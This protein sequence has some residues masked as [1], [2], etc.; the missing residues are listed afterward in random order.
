MSIKKP[1]RH[2]EATFERLCAAYGATCNK[3]TQDE[4]GWDYFVEF[5]RN[6]IPDLPLDMAPPPDKCL[7]QVKSSKD[8]LK[9]VRIKLS[10]AFEFAFT[11]LP[12]FIVLFVYNDHNTDFESVHVIHFWETEIARTLKRLRELDAKQKTD[13]HHYT[14]TFH[15]K[16]MAH[17]TDSE[18]MKFIESSI[19]R[20]SPTY[21]D[22]KRSIS[23]EVGFDDARFVA[24]IQFNAGVTIDEIVDMQ[25][26]LR[27]RI[28][29]ASFSARS[30]RF[31]IPAR[32]PFIES[33]GEVSM[34]SHPRACVLRVSSEASGREVSLPAQLY[35]PSLPRLPPI[36][37]RARVT[38]L[39]TELVF[40][41]AKSN[42][43]FTF[44]WDADTPYP[45]PDLSIL[46]NLIH[47][48]SS[49]SAHF[50][51]IDG[52]RPVFG[53]T[54]PVEAHQF[55][56]PLNIIDEFLKLLGHHIQP[57][58]IPTGLNAKLRDLIECVDSIAHFNALATE[59]NL[60]AT[61][62]MTWHDR[63]YSGPCHVIYPTAV[64]LPGFIV[65][66]IVR[67]KAEIHP[68]ANENTPLQLG[69]IDNVRIR[70]LSGSLE[71][72]QHAITSEV[73]ARA[74][75]HKGDPILA[76]LTLER[77]DK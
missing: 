70:V 31:G 7:V 32:L 44:R 66:A 41:P 43:N 60:P 49:G 69:E 77:D 9:G 39:F 10:N 15:T 63:P 58:D 25:I 29:A 76:I 16:D 48:F 47:I 36:H 59:E 22:K 19:H 11:D 61:C 27:D 45:I 33:A 73:Q 20:H 65:Y 30:K 42:L 75:E 1:P 37:L 5:P 57:H 62:E 21:S 4:K 50:R 34:R 40:E 56:Y 74:S 52:G 12:A 67:R 28:S 26:G 38:A 18:V 6:S 14:I 23:G 54:G 51:L 2:A 13:L 71:T 46:C 64:E 72:T 55:G 53:G 3:A 68:E 17:I 8:S 24:N 35:V